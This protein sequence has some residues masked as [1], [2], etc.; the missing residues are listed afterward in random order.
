MGLQNEF[1][2]FDN[3]QNPDFYTTLELQ[4]YG[5]KNEENIWYPHCPL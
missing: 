2:F 3:P 4:I 5:A 1:G